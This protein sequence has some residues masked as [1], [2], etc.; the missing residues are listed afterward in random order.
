MTDSVVRDFFR[1]LSPI[2]P[3]VGWLL[4]CVGWQGCRPVAEPPVVSQD[5]RPFE[6]QE[7]ALVVPTS[8]GLPELW[9][10]LLREWSVQT[11]GEVSLREYDPQDGA[12]LVT[13]LGQSSSPAVCLVPYSLLA[14][15]L[16]TLD[17]ERI[18]DSALSAVSGVAWEDL[19]SG[20]RERIGGPRRKPQVMPLRAPVLVCY[21]RKDLLERARLK[22][23]VT[24]DDYSRLVER[25]ADWGGGLP[26]A[27]PWSESFRVTWFLSRAVAAA[28]HPDNFSVFVDLETLQPMIDNPAFVA[29]LERA[30]AD[31][32]HLPADVWQWDPLECRRQVLEGRACL[33]IGFEPPGGMSSTGQAAPVP[34]AD[35]VVLGVCPLPAS[36]VAYNPSTKSLEEGSNR[37]GSRLFRSQLTGWEG[38]VA[39]VFQRKVEGS[40]IPAWNVLAQVAGPDY[41]TRFPPGLAGLTRESQLGDAN[42]IIGPELTGTESAEYLAV[43][44]DI[45]RDTGLVLEL[46]FPRHAEFANRLKGPLTAA[47]KGETAAEEALRQVSR[48]WSQLIE[49]IGREP[50]RRAYRQLLGLTSQPFS[51]P[52]ASGSATQRDSSPGS[53]PQALPR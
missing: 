8:L 16:T 29:A 20:V 2:C 43:T 1:W 9:E 51:T 23:P 33:A 22:P 40:A 46:P 47:L 32:A 45:L 17:L 12:N 35:G 28:R 24:W 41:L 14:D 53:A 50:F 52:S 3:L 39:C 5:Q 31:L 34:R 7:A 27:E 18:P 30:R 6:G 4:L 38:M 36:T 25:A 21:Y 37:S 49:E 13:V 15:T 10:P 42:L 44:A 26:V 11:G 48:D 19:M